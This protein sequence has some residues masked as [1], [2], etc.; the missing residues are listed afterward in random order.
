MSVR[1]L[2]AKN[3]LHHVE[4][5]RCGETAWWADTKEKFSWC[6]W[7]LWK[8]SKFRA[9]VCEYFPLESRLASCCEKLN[10]KKKIWALPRIFY[11]SENDEKFS[12]FSSRKFSDPCQRFVSRHQKIILRAS[13]QWSY[14]CRRQ[15][16]MEFSVAQTEFIN[17]NSQWEIFLIGKS[18]KSGGKIE[19]RRSLNFMKRSKVNEKKAHNSRKFVK[20]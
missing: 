8:L 18:I 4:F 13:S 3:I 11:F 20:V 15:Y 17:K 12:S 7:S 19:E 9:S 14:D 5:S 6:L 10:V 1:T 2:L 16:W